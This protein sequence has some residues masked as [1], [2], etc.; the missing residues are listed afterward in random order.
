MQKNATCTIFREG[1]NSI[2]ERIPA[3]CV[4]WQENSGINIQKYGAQNANKVTIFI[5]IPQNFE[6]KTGDLIMNGDVELE[7]DTPEK[8]AVLGEN[9]NVF[10]I[11]SVDKNDY[12]SPRLRHWEVG[13]K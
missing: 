10:T 9:Y 1:K 7:V 2:Y 3:G 4:F 5:P 12:G 6:P 13:A 8:I 11:M